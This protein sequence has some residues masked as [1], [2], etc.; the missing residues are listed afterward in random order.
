MA[1]EP[2]DRLPDAGCG[3]VRALP[4]P[5]EGGRPLAAGPG[6]RNSLEFRRFPVL[7]RARRAELRSYL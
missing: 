6:L 2:T 1:A 4:P 5:G 3:P 7:R